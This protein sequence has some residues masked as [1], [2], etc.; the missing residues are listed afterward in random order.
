MRGK[1][2]WPF[3]GDQ[4]AVVGVDD[5]RHDASC[6]ADE[7]VIDFPSVAPAVDR[8]RRA[9]V[10]DERGETLRAEIT[11]STREAREGTT[12]PLDVPVRCTCQ[13][14]G[15]R[16]E[17]WTE[18]CPPCRGSGVEFLSHQLHVLV[19]AGVIDG[20]RFCFTV[21]PRHHPSTRIELQVQIA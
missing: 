5:G 19:P 4:V 17:T 21:T 11:L 15:G 14:C 9:F 8:M 16:G 10:A 12:V 2:S 1:M 13:T 7:V 3:G 20:A 6:F 18:S